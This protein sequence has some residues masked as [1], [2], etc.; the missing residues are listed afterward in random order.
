MR[1]VYNEAIR[2]SVTSKETFLEA[3]SYKISYVNGPL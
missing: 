2:I 3:M 1:C